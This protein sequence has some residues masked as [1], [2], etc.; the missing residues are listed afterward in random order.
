VLALMPGRPSAADA[1]AVTTDPNHA[2]RAVRPLATLLGAVVVLA[3]AA[4][5]AFLAL[6]PPIDH[7][8]YDYAAMADVRTTWWVTHLCLAGP[9]FPLAFGGFGVLVAALCVRAGRGVVPAVAGAV[10]AGAGGLAAGLGFAAEAAV[11]GYLTDPDVVSPEAGT[12]ALHGI[13]AKPWLVDGPILGGFAA[14]GIG[15]VVLLAG[16]WR[17]GAVP[18][19]VPAAGIA[20]ALLAQAPWPAS[21]RAVP[22][23]L[24]T[25]VLVAI[26]LLAVHHLRRDAPVTAREPAIATSAG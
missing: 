19:G 1:T 5:L 4:R 20:V 8:L 16:L 9:G 15:V 24:D 25:A 23:V 17:S 7:H 3:A 13:E 14:L 12:R 26:T 2:H 11:W 10:L 18:R 21:L 22:G 6:H